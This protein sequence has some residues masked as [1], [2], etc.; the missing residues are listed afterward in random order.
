VW[1]SSGSVSNERILIREAYK[2]RSAVM[3]LSPIKLLL[4]GPALGVL[5]MIVVPTLNAQFPMPEGRAA[6][7]S[8]SENDRDLEARVASMRYLISLAEKRGARR[9]VDPKLALE[10]LQE[11]FTRIQIVNKDLVLRTDKTDKPDPRFVEKSAT[12]INKRAARLMSNLALPEPESDTPPV[13]TDVISDRTQLK[14]SI[15][16]LGWLIYRFT[17]NPMF[18]EAKVIEASA[19]ERARR[20]LVEIIARSNQLAQASEKLAKTTAK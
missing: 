19:A 18:K 16:A 5:L 2:M 9:K 15:T 3:K 13:K 10:Q 6:E 1:F 4:P 14:Q 17:K 8:R 12:E 11:D 7:R 20:D